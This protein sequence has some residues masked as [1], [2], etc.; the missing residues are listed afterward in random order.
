MLDFRLESFLCVCDTMNYR[1]SAQMLHITQPAITQHIH[2]LEAKFGCKLFVYENRLLK[3]THQ[4]RILEQ[5]ART[6]LAQEERLLRQLGDSRIQSL[7]IGATKTIG[8]RVIGEYVER[9]LRHPEHELSLTVDSTQNLLELID[10]SALDFALIEGSFPKEK[11]G[12][13]LFSRERFVGICAPEHPFAG[14]G[15]ALPELLNETLICRE[16]GSGTRAILENLLTEY[17]ES[18]SHFRRHVTISNFSVILELVQKNLGVSF[19]FEILARSSG[20]A[21][22]SLEGT[23]IQREFNFIYQKN[24]GNEEKIDYFM[25]QR[26]AY[27]PGN[28]TGRKKGSRPVGAGTAQP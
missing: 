13:R 6:M 24:S 16:Q 21:T 10:R 5:Y 3:K 27:P 7:S 23:N 9:F 28:D 26:G 18:I 14:R 12:H 11:Y 17:N 22:F 4:G 8:E 25:K 2:Y 15:V 19:V 1:K 20:L